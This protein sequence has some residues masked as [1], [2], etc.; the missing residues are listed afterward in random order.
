MRERGYAVDEEENERN[1]RCVGAA[2]RDRHGTAIAGI[3]V[4]GLTFTLK[5]DDVGLL[6]PMVV[7]AAR[8]I[9]TALGMPAE[10]N[11]S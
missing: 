8:R 5:E 11:G 10:R 4:S 2:V 6:G 7:A 3:S 9:S 1:V